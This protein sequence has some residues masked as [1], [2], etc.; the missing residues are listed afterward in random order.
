MRSLLTI[1]ALLLTVSVPALA[2][3]GE[4]GGLSYTTLGARKERTGGH[5]N[6][7]TLKYEGTIEKKDAAK[8]SEEAEKPPEEEEAADGAWEKYKALAA[9]QYE[10]PE[11]DGQEPTTPKPRVVQEDDTPSPGLAGIIE[12][13]NK[14]KVQRSQMRSIRVAPP[15]EESE[16]KHL[17]VSKDEAEA[18][19]EPVTKTK[20]TSYRSYTSVSESSCA[21]LTLSCFHLQ[22]HTQ[23]VLSL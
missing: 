23:Y 17:K 12:Q 13:Y 19:E 20:K 4:N 6:H 5:M 15:E 8:P 14:N 11:D 10:E 2:Q 3:Q 9:G 16:T 18:T 1:S 22:Y 21:A 7:K